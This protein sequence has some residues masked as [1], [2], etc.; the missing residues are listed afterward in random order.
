MSGA[1]GMILLNGMG[2]VSIATR[3]AARVGARQ[4]VLG[5]IG[6]FVAVSSF[7]NGTIGIRRRLGTNGRVLKSIG[8]R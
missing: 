6:S 1:I 7:Q 2:Q 4:R 3:S 5:L 8:A